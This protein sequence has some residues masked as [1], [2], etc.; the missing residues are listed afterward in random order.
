MKLAESQLAWPLSPPHE[1]YSIEENT[2]SLL[3]PD[4]SLPPLKPAREVLTLTPEARGR[5][6][7]AGCLCT[8]G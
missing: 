6:G 5:P 1:L 3:C 7:G 2:C 8:G 4:R